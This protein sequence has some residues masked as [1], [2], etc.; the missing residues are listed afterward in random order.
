[1]IGYEGR[2]G[3]RRLTRYEYRLGQITD[4][5][6]DE[7]ARAN[8]IPIENSEVVEVRQGDRTEP[9][10][11]A[12]AAFRDSIVSGKPAPS[13]GEYSL[14]TLAA[15]EAGAHSLAQHGMWTECAA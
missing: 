12:C 10:L 1:M 6:L 2:F 7:L 13:S 3:K 15:L 8:L 11:L 9:L 4:S 14:R 5:S